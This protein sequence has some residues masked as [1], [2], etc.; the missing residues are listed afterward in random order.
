MQTII[1]LIFE[2][3]KKNGSIKILFILNLELDTFYFLVFFFFTLHI[4]SKKMAIKLNHQGQDYY[5]PASLYPNI[6]RVP[7]RQA[8][9]WISTLLHQHNVNV[10]TAG[11]WYH[12]DQNYN[13]ERVDHNNLQLDQVRW[14]TLRF[15]DENKQVV[16]VTFNF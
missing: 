3:Q 4:S 11:T 10:I 14:E 5:L 6:D 8:S 13:W 16:N 12:R 9:L 2:K 15:I 1:G 7:L